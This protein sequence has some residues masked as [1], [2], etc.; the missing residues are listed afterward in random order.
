[1]TDD[2]NLKRRVLRHA[3][4]FRR[5]TRGA[6]ELRTALAE[7]GEVVEG[8]SL[9]QRSLVVWQEPPIAEMASGSRVLSP[10]WVAWSSRLRLGL[11]ISLRGGERDG[12]QVGAFLFRKQHAVRLA[13]LALA[14]LSN[15]QKRRAAFVASLEEELAQRHSRS[16]GAVRQ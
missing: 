7:A 14:A 15:E 5:L 1:M 4:T 8:G 11:R 3:A 2:D 16:E 10:H 12:R 13:H 9:S 6:E